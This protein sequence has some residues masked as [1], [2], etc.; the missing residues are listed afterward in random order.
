M[1]KK[2]LVDIVHV[3]LA[4]AGFEK[5]LRAGPSPP[6][7]ATIHS[8]ILST[9]TPAIPAWTLSLYSF[10]VLEDM[11]CGWKKNCTQ[12]KSCLEEI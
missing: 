7:S 1:Q 10:W 2:R 12:P 8:H 3:V 6:P 11:I 9:L 5:R 4:P